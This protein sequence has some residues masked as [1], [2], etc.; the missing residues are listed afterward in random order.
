MDESMRYVDSAAAELLAAAREAQL[1]KGD[2]DSLLGKYRALVAQITDE[3]PGRVVVRDQADRAGLVRDCKELA[4]S[5]RAKAWNHVGLKEIFARHAVE[6]GLERQAPHPAPKPP[7]RRKTVR[8]RSAPIVTADR[9]VRDTDEQ[10]LA[11]TAL[12]PGTAED[13][14]D[15]AVRA[16]LQPDWLPLLPVDALAAAVQC[17][18][19]RRGTALLQRIDGRL[20]EAPTHVRRIDSPRNPPG[21]RPGIGGSHPGG[22]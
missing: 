11:R 21:P 5:I 20:Q 14:L 13:L 7:G 6:W 1:G 16:I 3:P 18:T 9:N 17:I 22:S 4:I 15:M 12:Q 2:I 19:T 10:E 8:R